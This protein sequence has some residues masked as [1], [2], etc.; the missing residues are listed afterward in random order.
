MKNNT[1]KI[2]PAK[3]TAAEFKILGLA[4]LLVLCG[5]LGLD[6]HLASLPNIMTYMHT[7]KQ[8]MQQSVTFF[9]LGVALSL[10]VYGPLSDKIGRKIVVIF[11]L[12]IACICS[13]MATMSTSIEIFLIFRLLQGIGSG[14]CWGLGRVIVA[15]VLQGERLAALGSYL[16]MFVS[17]SPMLAPALGGYM[18]SWFGWQSNFILLGVFIFVVLM[19]LVFFLEETNKNLNADAFRIRPLA[20]NYLSFF[21]ERVFVGCMLLSGISMSATIIYVTMSSFIYQHEFGVSP[22]F[23]GWLSV[24][25]GIV[26]VI[27]K[28]ISPKVIFRLKRYNTLILGILIILFSGLMLSVCIY[29]GF[30]NKYWVLLSASLRAVGVLFI[31]MIA[32]SMALSPFSNNRG[33]AGALYGSFQLLIPFLFSGIITSSMSLSGSSILALAMIGLSVMGLLVYFFLIKPSNA[34]AR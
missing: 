17:L 23:F 33:S 3:V 13:F 15:D 21:K 26:G 24:V 8:H 14:V 1:D 28:A 18:Q 5:S 19:A 31:A 22:I 30:N 12:S 29:F 10:L 34:G 4:I 20:L 7:D 25:V 16:S 9:I 27:G 11:G 32:M 6:I 2:R